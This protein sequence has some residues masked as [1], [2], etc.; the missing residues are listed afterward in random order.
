MKAIDS[1]A[2][3][4]FLLNTERFS[5][6]S[7]HFDDEL[8]ATDLV[9][10]ETLNA[11]RKISLRHPRAARRIDRAVEVLEDLPI[12]WVPLQSLSSQIWRLRGSITAYDAAHVAVARAGNCPLLTADQRLVRAAPSGLQTILV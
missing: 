2:L 9:V 11:L 5:A 1:S 6:V 3:V 10:P 7:H 8:I 4:E 12:D